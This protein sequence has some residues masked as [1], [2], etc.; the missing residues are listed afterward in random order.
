MINCIAE[1]AKF[2]RND[3]VEMQLGTDD[4]GEDGEHS[5]VGFMDIKQDDFFN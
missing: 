5:D 1:A 2:G 4:G 3:A